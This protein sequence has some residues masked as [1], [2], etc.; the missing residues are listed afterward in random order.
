MIGH[1]TEEGPRH[2]TDSTQP[3]VLRF[4]VPRSDSGLVAALRVGHPDARSALC[5][6]HSGELLRIATRI[7]GP[8]ACIGP[9]VVETLQQSLDNLQD[10]ADPRL[11]RTWLLSR[12]LMAARGRLRAQHRWRGLI[13]CHI[14]NWFDATR[15]SE[16]LVSSYWILACLNVEQRMAFSLVEID[17]MDPTEAAALLGVSEEIMKDWLGAAHT[18]FARLAR[19]SFPRL[20]EQ[21][22]SLA[23]LGARLAEEQDRMLGDGRIYE[24][25]LLRPGDGLGWRSHS[26]TKRSIWSLAILS[27]LVVLAFGVVALV[28]R[29]QGA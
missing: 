9:L 27:L 7:M 19:S 23:S 13:G 6:R 15:G 29:L 14:G 25:D 3:V 21:H 10:L 5:E 12:L 17:W 26:L 22:S 1:P 4:P 18:R 20:I 28:I 24:F 16:R 8:D 11:L 2:R